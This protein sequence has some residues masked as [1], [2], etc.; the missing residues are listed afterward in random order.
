VHRTFEEDLQ[1]TQNPAFRT[2]LRGYEP[3][4]V[5]Q[6]TAE[7]IA[8][9]RA[10]REDVVRLTRE[11]E[12]LRRALE[13]SQRAQ[14]T[15]AANQDPQLPAPS[16][17]QQLGTR[18]HQ[19]LSL[20]EEEA[21]EV[22]ARAKEEA[23]SI[24][25]AGESSVRTLRAEADRYD[26]TVRADADI[27]VQRLLSEAHRQAEETIDSAH[28]D[29]TARREEAEALWEGHRAKAAQAAADFEVTL[30]ARRARAE[31]DFIARTAAAE[32]QLE[33]VERAAAQAHLQSEREVNEA[34]TR[35]R[36]M[37]ADAHEE[38]TRLVEEARERA[39]RMRADSERELT[40]AGYR[41]D[42]I[43]AQLTNVRQMLATLSGSVPVIGFESLQAMADA[44]PEGAITPATSPKSQQ[45]TA[46]NA[47]QGGEVDLRDAED[48]REPQAAQGRGGVRAR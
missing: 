27:E 14:A 5:D 19:I 45:Q 37:L 10:R 30:A 31:E 13:Q 20:A 9:I 33:T 15:A 6:R 7:M 1:M 17:F 32:H 40:A 25:A 2:V 41:R 21:A 39:E 16:P 28:R 47:R 43:N 46:P 48:E 42:S 44:E 34:T 26:A 18:I 29:A 38:A 36:Q 23:T 12:Q 24:R 8:E 3:A 4:Q 11:G 35:S 22:V